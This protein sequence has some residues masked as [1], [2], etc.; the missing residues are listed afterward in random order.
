MGR[1]EY[2]RRMGQLDV[3]L[4]NMPYLAGEGF[5]LADIPAGFVVH[6]WYSM[7]S[8]ERTPMLALDAYYERLSARPAYRL[9]IRNGL[10]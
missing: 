3:A 2:A 10:P 7:K 9:H 4:R 6:R 5:T 1:A 8:V